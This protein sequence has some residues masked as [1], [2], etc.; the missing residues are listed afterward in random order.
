[1]SAL[2]VLQSCPPQRKALLDSLGVVDPANTN[3]MYF[4]LAHSTPRLHH[5]IAFQIQVQ[6]KGTTIHH[7][8]V[9]EGASTCIMSLNYWRALGSPALVPSGSMLKSFDAHTSKPHGIILVF[10]NEL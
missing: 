8:V 9:D 2:E 3:I 7:C 6:T 10:P 1:M 5:H 4:D